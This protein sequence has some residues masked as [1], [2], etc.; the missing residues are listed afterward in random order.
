MKNLCVFCGS[1]FGNRPEYEVAARL[2]GLELAGR[3]IRLIYGGGRV[4]L[5]GVVADAVMAA[6]GEV[7][8]VIPEFLMQKEIGHVGLTELHV[9]DS[10][11]SRKAKM[12][13]LADGFVALP[14]GF[15]TFEEFFEILTWAQLGM[16][17]KP[18]GLLDVADFYL[19]MV[20]FLRH[21]AAQGFIRND[22]LSLIVHAREPEDLIQ[23]LS[24]YQAVTVPKWLDRTGA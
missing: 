18:V 6:G 11:H 12:A 3:G 9:V 2:L 23:R 24:G 13:E 5:M 15:G 8:G 20:A 16:H 17:S 10:M 1:Q 7:V 14:G 4:G 19:P 21:S 22:H